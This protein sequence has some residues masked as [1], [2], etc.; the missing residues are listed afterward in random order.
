MEEAYLPIGGRLF[1]GAPVV[2]LA[3]GDLEVDFLPGHGMLCMSL[4]DRKIEIL[5]RVDDLETAASKGSTAGI[6]LLHP[7]ANRL[8]KLGYRAAG[9]EVIL[10]RAS[11]KLHFDDIGLPLHGV[12]WA[13]L[14]WEV[15]S[16][17]H[18]HLTARLDWRGDDLLRIYP[19]PHRMELTVALCSN[20][21][22]FETMLVADSS[23]IP[24]PISFGFRP[25]VRIPQP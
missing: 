13:Q 2:T 17:R 7:W 11:P 15:I 8:S 22:T 21:L 19:F 20:A 23:W 12:P 25:S 18:D 10:D 14:A 3:S 16:M 9:I 5:R 6:P 4:R 1:K 24:V